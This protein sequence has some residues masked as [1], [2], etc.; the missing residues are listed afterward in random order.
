VKLFPALLKLVEHLDAP[1]QAKL[2]SG[3]ARKAYRV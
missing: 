1:T 2:F 3:N